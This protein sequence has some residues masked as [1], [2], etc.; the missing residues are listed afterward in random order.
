MLGPPHDRAAASGGAIAR[1]AVPRKSLGAAVAAAER[2]Q[3]SFSAFDFNMRV[4]ARAVAFAMLAGAALA[5]PVF[6]DGAEAIMGGVA[7]QQREAPA[8]GTDDH[9]AAQRFGRAAAARL[10]HDLAAAML[11]EEL[12][13]DGRRRAGAAWQAAQRRRRTRWPT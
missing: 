10:E 6:P 2:A 11:R 8:P 4:A 9:L 1:G 13:E 3:L 7:A 5:Q 12:D